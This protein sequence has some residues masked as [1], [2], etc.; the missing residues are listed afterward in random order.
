[1]SMQAGD[2]LILKRMKRRHL[3]A[4]ALALV[5]QLKARRPEIAIGADLIAG[6]PTES[7][8]HHAA[9]L[10]V[11]RDLGVVHGHVFPYSAREGT[12]AARMPQVDRSV[13]KERARRLREKGEAALRTHLDREVGASRRVLAESEGL[14][15]TEQFTA[16]R[17]AA[18]VAP[19]T[20]MDV[21]LTAHDG[22]YLLAA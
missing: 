19:G 12:P 18:P 7:A 3:R 5:E 10:S 17:L 6:F 1:M 22:R 14:A 21:T 4:D 20:L 13:V 15:R 11:I 2:D 9:N 8:E 16:V